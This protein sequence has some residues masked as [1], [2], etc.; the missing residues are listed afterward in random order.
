MPNEQEASQIIIDLFENIRAAFIE[1]DPASL[2]RELGEVISSNQGETVQ[3][4][5]A[6]LFSPRVAGGGGTSSVQAFYDIEINSLREIDKPDGFSATIS[7]FA[8]VSAMHW[9]H[10]DRRQFQFQ[11]LLDLIEVNRQWR[12]TELTLVDIKEA[13]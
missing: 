8:D 6:K 5:L 4:E 9:G 2:A 13:R 7:G 12:L 11:M 3:K 1:K 10:T